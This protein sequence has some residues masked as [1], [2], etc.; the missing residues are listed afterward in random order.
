MLDH[1]LNLPFADMCRGA[2]RLTRVMFWRHG[3]DHEDVLGHVGV[4]RERLSACFGVGVC[5]IVASRGKRNA[6]GRGICLVHATSR[7]ALGTV[8]YGGSTDHPLFVV[9]NG[10]AAH[11]LILS[12]GKGYCDVVLGSCLDLAC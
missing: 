6:A 3:W 5:N 4:V 9:R 8:G 12:I 10:K 7:G 2:G 1:T 11:P